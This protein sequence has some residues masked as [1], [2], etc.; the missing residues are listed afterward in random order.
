MA[1]KAKGGS[2][3]GKKKKKAAYYSIAGES[4]KRGKRF[5]PKCGAGVFMAEHADRSG[6]GRCG[7]TEWK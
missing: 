7:Y 4:L 5:C 1:E 3:K 2:G 6:C